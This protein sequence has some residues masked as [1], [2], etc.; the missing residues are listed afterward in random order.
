MKILLI[1]LPILALPL[2]RLSA[3]GINLDQ[4]QFGIGFVS[5]NVSP[6]FSHIQVGNLD[7]PP[8]NPNYEFTWNFANSEESAT[9]A[10]TT[11]IRGSLRTIAKFAFTLSETVDFLLSGGVR[12]SEGLPSAF[13]SLD[14]VLGP[15]QIGSSVLDIISVGLCPLL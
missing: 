2:T 4:I 14:A 5:L 7:V 11:Y 12:H 9:F 10:G 8:E 13:T 15:Y 6:P 3:I 1:F